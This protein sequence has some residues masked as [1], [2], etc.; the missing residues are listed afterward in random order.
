MGNRLQADLRRDHNSVYG[1]NTTGR[2]GTAFEVA[3]GLKLRALAGTTFRAP[4]FNDLHFPGFGIATI[5]PERG[6]SIEAGVAWQSGAD[7]ASLTVYRNQVRNLINFQP[8]RTFC[9]AD[10]A[11]NFGCAGNVG[12]A[13][14]QG[15]TLA[16]AKRW[17][18]LSVRATV[19]LLDA[20]DADSGQRLGRRAAQQ[21]SLAADYDVGRWRLGG[22]LLF[23][24][25]RP[26]G[27][28]VLGGYGTLNLRAVWRLQPQWRLEAKL[29]NALDPRVEPFRDYQGLG[30]QAWIG[31]RYES[32]RALIFRRALE[33]LQMTLWRIEQGEVSALEAIESLLGEEYTT[34]ESRRIKMALQTARLPTV[35]TLSGYDFSFQPSLDRNR[36]LGACRARVRGAASVRP[37]ARAAGHG[38]VPS[39]DRPRRGGG[40]RR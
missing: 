8:D 38:Q 14:L 2:V 34:R 5:Q 15:A 20:K 39:G 7:N 19:V 10:P 36:V 32:V 22:S 30:R 37:S 11:F 4:T 33:A 16:G 35:K 18:D 21:E 29:L 24:G 12:R 25:S 31:V 28:V 40:A 27:G 3:P 17:G 23:V 9:P 6:S 13:R 1:N 26:D